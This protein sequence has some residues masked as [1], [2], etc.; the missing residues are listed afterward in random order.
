M[1][2]VYSDID[3]AAEIYVRL[4][5]KLTKSRKPKRFRIYPEI[6]NEEGVIHT[7]PQGVAETFAL[8]YRKLYTP[9]E[10]DSF[11]HPFRNT[12]IDKY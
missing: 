10:D 5:W 12:I 11:D 7:D 1:Q 9:L 4:F 3:K 8:F 2:R 6:R